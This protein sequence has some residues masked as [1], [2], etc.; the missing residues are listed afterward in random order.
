MN[1]CGSLMRART[2][3]RPASLVRSSRRPACG[4][5]AKLRTRLPQA[6]SAG[7][8][9][10]TSWITGGAVSRNGFS[11]PAGRSGLTSSRSLAGDDPF[12]QVEMPPAA[13]RPAD[14]LPGAHALAGGHQRVD[15]PVAEVADADVAADAMWCCLLDDAAF[16]RVDPM[17]ATLGRAPFGPVV[18]DRDVDAGVVDGAERGVWPRVEEGA[19][20]RVLPVVRSHGPAAEGVV[21][22]LLDRRHAQ[23]SSPSRPKRRSAPGK[24]CGIPP[25]CVHV[26]ETAVI[27]ASGL[28]LRQASV[29]ERRVVS[30]V[31]DDLVGDAPVEL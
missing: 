11:F 25:E 1:D 16:D 3:T 18:A 28:R 23:S 27:G 26:P 2:S 20:D 19:A 17:R 29:Q 7:V 8:W 13:A 31:E 15:M 6:G 10:R 4:S 30:L 12:G 22:A 24:S 14:V 21:V 9:K 5:V